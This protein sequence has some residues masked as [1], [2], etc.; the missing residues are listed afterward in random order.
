[1]EDEY[2]LIVVGLGPAG[3]AL[4]YSAAKN[5]LKVLGIDKRREIGVPIQCGEFI[6]RFD[7]FDELLPE[8]DEKYKSIF[9]NIPNNLV[10][11]KTEKVRL[12]TPFNT[13]YEVDFLGWVVD[14]ERFDKWLVSMGVSKGAHI[15][16]NTLVY[17]IDKDG[18]V[19]LKLSNEEVKVKGDVVAI[20]AGAGS[21][22]LDEV[23]LYREKDEY[24]L[25]HVM[26]YVMTGIEA[27]ESVIEM[28]TGKR[29]SPGAYAWIIPRGNGFAN[30]GVGIRYPYVDEEI[31]LRDY[32]HR[33]IYEHPIAK[34][35]LRNAQPLS[36]IGGIVP[37]GPPAKKTVVERFISLGDSANHV[38]ASLGAG[39]IT[40]VIAGLIA[41]EA[42]ANHIKYGSPL[43]KY[44]DMWRRNIGRV[45]KDGY[46][47][48]LAI[49]VL[50]RK[51]ELIEYGM[52]FI[53]K[54]Y[55]KNLVYTKAP[56]VINL[57]TI[58]EKLARDLKS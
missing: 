41:G 1:M 40:A 51:D 45:L 53:G 35:K 9:R 50:T 11:N 46:K 25:G 55:L 32:L 17:K 49:D 54:K 29:Y 2:D 18:D 6:P 20:A 8:T 56:R 30:V 57:A 14:R 44:E 37:V 19:Y 5:G 43:S 12:Y 52:K 31:G 4:L 34:E 22:L 39:I 36:M 7:E 16:I 47:L 15:L 33:F 13:V 48:R 10:L 24:N 58:L 38:I 3:A 27:D 23:G 26:Q 28:Y 21:H 42:V